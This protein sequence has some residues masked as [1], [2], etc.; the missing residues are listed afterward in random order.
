MRVGTVAAV[1]LSLVALRSGLQPLSDNSFLTHLATGRLLLEG[2]FPRSDPY[3][4]TAPGTD[5]VVQS[6][7]ASAVYASVDRAL[8]GAGLVLLHGGLVAA[9]AGLACA[10]ATKARALVPFL[11]IALLVVTIGGSTWSERP[12]LFGLIGLALTLLAADGRLDPRWLVPVFWVWGNT[13]GSFPLGLVA[14]GALAA[15]SVLD[16][17]G[18]D[19]E[20]AAMRWAGLG[21]L[22]AA[23]GPLGHRVL[24]FPLAMLGRSEV[25]EAVVEWQAPRFRDLDERLFLLQVALCIVALA[26]RPSYRAA[27]PTVVFVVAALLA[28]RNVGA[29]SLVLIGP[30]ASGLAGLGS[31]TLDARLRLGRPVVL[32]LAA[33]GALLAAVSVSRPAFDLSAYPVAELEG[34]AGEERV[35]APDFVGNYRTATDARR[36]AVYVDDRYDMYPEPVLRGYLELLRGRPGWAEVLDDVGATAVV[37][38]VDLPLASLLRAAEDDWRVVSVDDG[39]LVARRR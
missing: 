32:A 13:H 15:G 38:P 4:F 37:W 24:T 8:G 20:L 6:W 9:L 10:L 33:V 34:L 28:A 36:G 29:A 26:R 30:T 23:V 39:W 3:S 16:R 31:L 11:G 22:A 19:V 35:V 21:A 17:R 25:L 14:L 12:L 2:G 27:V 5:W 7:L 18:A 1:V